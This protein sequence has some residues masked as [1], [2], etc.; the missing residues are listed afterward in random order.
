MRINTLQYII[1]IFQCPPMPINIYSI[2]RKIMLLKFRDHAVSEN[3]N[4]NFFPAI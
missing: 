3:C 1:N 2:H 4:I